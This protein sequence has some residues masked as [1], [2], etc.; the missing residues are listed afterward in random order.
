MD[1]GGILR[2]GSGNLIPVASSD[3]N[4]STYTFNTNT[5]FSRVPGVPLI[6]GKNPNCGCIDPN[7]NQQ[8]LNPAAWVGYARRHMGPG[9][10]LLQRLSLAAS[11]DART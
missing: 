1:L 4:L 9:R 3:T 11:G 2:Y 5:R 6:P 8:I 7:S 10:S